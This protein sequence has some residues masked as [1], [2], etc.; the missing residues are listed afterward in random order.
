MT[1]KNFLLK[2]TEIHNTRVYLN[3]THITD[4]LSVKGA[5]LVSLLENVNVDLNTTNFDVA[6]EGEGYMAE[7]TSLEIVTK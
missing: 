6:F 7:W 3:N 1:L 2:I 5:H 4:A